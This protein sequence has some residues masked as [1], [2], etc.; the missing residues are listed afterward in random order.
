L[1]T[2]RLIFDHLDPE[3]LVKVGQCSKRFYALANEACHWNRI[4]MDLTGSLIE[5]KDLTIHLLRKY[6]MYEIKKKEE[7]FDYFVNPFKKLIHTDHWEG[8]YVLF[9]CDSVDNLPKAVYPRKD[10]T[11]GRMGKVVVYDDYQEPDE[12]IYGILSLVQS[13]QKKSKGFML[14]IND[15]FLKNQRLFIKKLNGPEVYWAKGG[16]QSFYKEKKIAKIKYLDQINKLSD[17]QFN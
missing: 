15:D 2:I 12:R 9:S 4:S 5:K 10:Y 3:Q 7:I 13:Y 16:W 17:I 8:E 11:Y 6:H 14:I 1:D